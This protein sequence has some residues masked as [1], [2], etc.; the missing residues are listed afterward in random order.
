MALVS[1]FTAWQA[2]V[3]EQDSLRPGSSTAR[4][5]S[6][7]EGFDDATSQSPFVL[8]AGSRVKPF[9]EELGR[10]MGSQSTYMKLLV[11]GGLIAVG[12]FLAYF[13]WRFRK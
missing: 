9:L 10:G 3:L 13:A 2:Y 7:T 11:R 5:E 4:V 8:V 1:A 12:M 6:Y